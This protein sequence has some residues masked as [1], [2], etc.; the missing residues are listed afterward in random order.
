M[1]LTV[2][3]LKMTVLAFD[4][5]VG[6]LHFAKILIYFDLISQNFE[7]IKFRTLYMHHMLIAFQTVAILLL[8]SGNVDQYR[9]IYYIYSY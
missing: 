8:I 2:K 1:N 5:E 7:P 9:N 6:K 3:P 4:H